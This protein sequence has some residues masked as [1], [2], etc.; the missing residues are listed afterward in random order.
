MASDICRLTEIVQLTLLGDSWESADLGAALFDGQRR[1][2]AANP[3]YCALTGY[4]REE[5]SSLSAG[6]S[7]L[8]EELSGAEFI[9]RI[10]RH[11]Y[12]GQLMIRREDGTLLPINYM[13]VPTHVSE[14]RA[15]VS[16]IWPQDGDRVE[17]PK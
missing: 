7:L 15:F 14:R 4:S 6:Q 12:V 3:A 9:A 5:L 8:A 11:D 13:I 10:A 2:L 17:A 16:I 1:I